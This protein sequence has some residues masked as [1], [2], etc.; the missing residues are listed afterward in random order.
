[1]FIINIIVLPSVIS[2]V[3][4]DVGRTVA[5]ALNKLSDNDSDEVCTGH[6]VPLASTLLLIDASSSATT[7]CA[8]TIIGIIRISA[9]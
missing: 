7:C 5:M 8:P 1:M 2:D 3:A 6:G 9:Q 4:C